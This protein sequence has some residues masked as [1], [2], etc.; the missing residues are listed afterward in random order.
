MDVPSTT[1]SQVTHPASPAFWAVTSS[2]SPSRALKSSSHT[3]SR[4]SVT[5]F[6]SV[7][8]SGLRYFRFMFIALPCTRY[9]TRIPAGS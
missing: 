3:A 9:D 4:G 6:S 7:R 5:R 1:I 8:P 2:R